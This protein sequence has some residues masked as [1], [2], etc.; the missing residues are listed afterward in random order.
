[1]TCNI[2]LLFSNECTISEKIILW[3]NYVV[4]SKFQG[5][6]AV[7][8][9]AINYAHDVKRSVLSYWLEWMKT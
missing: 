9:I 1:M 7:N 4:A 6:N 5:S 3:G 2:A 8:G